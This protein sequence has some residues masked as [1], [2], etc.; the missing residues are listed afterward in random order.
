MLD[1][2]IT[3]GTV[4]FPGV[5]LQKVDVGV[6]GERIAGF[7]GEGET[8]EARRAIDASG[9]VVMPGAIDPHVHFGIYQPL[10]EDTA[11]D[12]KAAA[13]GGYT[14]VVNYYRTAAPYLDTIPKVIDD[15]A[16]VS[17]IDFGLSLGLLTEQHVAE[18]EQSIRELGVTS[19]KFYRNY[20]GAVRTVFGIEDPLNLDDAD[21]VDTL[22]RM[23]EISDELVLCVHCEDMALQR[24]IIK[25]MKQGPVENSLAALSRTS[26]G[27]G[28]AVS[29]LTTL[30]LNKIAGGNVF[31][32]HL[33][34]GASVDV[35]EQSSWLLE[36]TGAVI[37]TTPHYLILNEESPCGLLAKVGPPIHSAKDSERLWDGVSKGLITSLGSDNVPNTYAKKT[38]AGTDLWGT[39]YG[40]GGIGL[41]LP[42]MISEGYHKRGIP[43]ETIASLTSQQPARSFGLYPRK[44]AMQVSAD[45][46]LVLVDL[47][48]ERDVTTDLPHVACDYSVYEGM[49]VKGWPVMTISRG[50]VI[51][52]NDQV[53]GKPGRGQYLRRAI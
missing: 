31:V 52:E 26:P 27:Y 38:E 13:L 50:E 44:G 24:S 6:R 22:R 28:E 5:G 36:S 29:L 25:Q 32:V 40:F 16:Q 39:K 48:K 17:T 4:V 2:L 49:K 51:A 37:E 12:T 19:W 53:L 42:L 35:L 11:R 9:L 14:S 45:A 8:L 41:E 30:Y 1:L 18:F 46:D 3:H 23:Q 15:M 43:L 21:F 33:S 7:Y 10:Q 47:E 20:Q 34:A